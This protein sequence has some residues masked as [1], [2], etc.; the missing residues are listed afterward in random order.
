MLI[1]PGDGPALAVPAPLWLAVVARAAL[2]VAGGI[3]PRL[4]VEPALRAVT[5]L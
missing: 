5:G 2:V 1:V 4:F 3:V